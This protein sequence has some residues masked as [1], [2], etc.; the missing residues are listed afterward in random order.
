MN[1]L[2]IDDEPLARSEL[3]YLLE[4]CYE[5]DFVDEGADGSEMI[6]K[7][8]DNIFHAVFLDI[9]LRNESGLDLAKQL[10]QLM[11]PPIIVFATAYDDYAVKAFERNATDYILKPFDLNRIKQTVSRV[12]EKYLAMNVQDQHL[13]P[14]KKYPIYVDDRILLIDPVDIFAIEVQ[15]GE[16]TIFTKDQEYKSNEPLTLWEKRLNKRDFIRVHRSFMLRID[17]ISEIQPWFNH[18]YQTTLKN[19]LKIPVSRSYLKVF[20]SRIGF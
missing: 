10:N 1:V 18:T 11:Y 5:I 7:F 4:Q 15:R 6:Q 9:Q 8:E 13:N 12:N 3:K 17:S 14:H 20:R 19:G 16:T 2:V